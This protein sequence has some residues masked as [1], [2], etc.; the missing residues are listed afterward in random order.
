VDIP[1]E[2]KNFRPSDSYNSVFGE[3]DDQWKV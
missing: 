2:P 3:E 1:T